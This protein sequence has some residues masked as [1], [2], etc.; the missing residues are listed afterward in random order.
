MCFEK[1]ALASRIFRL[2]CSSSLLDSS[3]FDNAGAALSNI[4][5]TELV[6]A[7]PVDS[8]L[9][10]AN[11]SRHSSSRS[12]ARDDFLLKIVHT[13]Q[14]PVVM[15]TNAI[16]GSSVSISMIIALRGGTGMQSMQ[17]DGIDANFLKSDQT[18]MS[19]IFLI[20]T[21]P[22]ICM[23]TATVTILRPISRLNKSITYS[24]FR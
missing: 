6:L 19:T 13:A 23:M 3:A 7:P 5:P 1:P 4:A 24:G 11:G 8:R 16:T 20:T 21:A 10:R 12:A 9:C 15:A 18:L 22:T 14:K 2:L 17:I